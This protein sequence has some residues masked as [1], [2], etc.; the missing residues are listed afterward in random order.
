MNGWP[1]LN[2]SP[3]VML[4]MLSVLN[5]HRLRHTLE[6]HQALQN[7]QTLLLYDAGVQVP[8]VQRDISYQILGICQHVCGDHVGALNSYQ[9]SLQQIPL[10]KIQQASI[11]RMQSLIQA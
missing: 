11:Y 4:H 2:I 10:H 1:Q 9:Y 8:V 7:L 5:H 3:Q 6:S